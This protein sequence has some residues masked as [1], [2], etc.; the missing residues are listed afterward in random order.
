MFSKKKKKKVITCKLPVPTPSYV[1][2]KNQEV[3]STFPS[4][5]LGRLQF[6]AENTLVF[7]KRPMTE[8]ESATVTKTPSKSQESS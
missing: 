4:L 1:L 2:K 7:F 5:L 6:C 8:M 3:M